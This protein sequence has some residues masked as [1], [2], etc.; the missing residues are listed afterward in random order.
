MPTNR[1]TIVEDVLDIMTKKGA[2]VS[3]AM[4]ELIVAETINSINR[5]VENLD[6][7]NLRGFGSFHFKLRAQR[8]ARNPR[9]LEEV[10][11]PA[12]T[13]VIFRPAR[14]LRMTVI[15]RAQPRS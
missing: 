8:I 14:A 2:K 4:V 1:A 9:S 3:T 6:P 13:A 5:R 11:L 7:V 12:H 15:R 10:L